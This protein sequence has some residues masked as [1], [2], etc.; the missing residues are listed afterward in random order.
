[1]RAL[2][3]PP[4]D[5]KAKGKAWRQSTDPAGLPAGPKEKSRDM[6]HPVAEV[7][8]EASNSPF[9]ICFVQETEHL[10]AKGVGTWKVQNRDGQWSKVKVGCVIR[11]HSSHGRVSLLGARYMNVIGV[12]PTYQSV[13]G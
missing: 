3:R 4:Q 11:L 7:S 2:R 13:L 1:M 12:G 9:L 6:G 8:E 10:K 5:P